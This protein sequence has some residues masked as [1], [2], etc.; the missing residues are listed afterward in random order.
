MLGTEFLKNARTISQQ[1]LI[2]LNMVCLTES[3]AEYLNYNSR[4]FFFEFSTIHMYVHVYL[5]VYFNCYFNASDR[6]T[7]LSVGL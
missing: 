6:S 1:T 7:P 2:F 5:T 3:F 4:F